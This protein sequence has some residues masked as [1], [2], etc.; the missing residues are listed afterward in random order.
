MGGTFRQAGRILTH[1]NGSGSDIDVDDVV[2]IGDSVGVALVDIPDG[3]KG[4]VSVEGVH[5]LAK[6]T[7]TAWN[8]GDVLSWDASE[9]AFGKG[10]TPAAGDVIG[11]AIA[12]ADATSAAATGEVKLANPGAA[13]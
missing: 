2:V 10:I 5:Q 12:A 4:A 9:A 3:E 6:V 7:G 1:E 11:C 13:E 8:Q